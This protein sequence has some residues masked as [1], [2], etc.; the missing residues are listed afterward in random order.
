MSSLSY[1]EFLVRQEQYKD[2]LYQAQQERMVKL[3]KPRPGRYRAVGKWVGGKVQRTS[4]Q[5]R[6][7]WFNSLERRSY[8]ER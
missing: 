6:C 5:V 7:T 3:F 2:L 4:K 1:V 8:I